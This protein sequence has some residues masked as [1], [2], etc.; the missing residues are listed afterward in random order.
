MSDQA[1]LVYLFTGDGKGK[2]S[3]ALGVAFRSLAAGLKVAMVQWYKDPTWRISEHSIDTLLTAEAKSRFKIYPM[4]VG[5]FIQQQAIQLSSN[6][7][8]QRINTAPLSN[9][10]VVVDKASEQQHQAAAQAALTK[11][12]EVLSTVDVLILDE[13]NN[14]I[15]DKL[16]SVPSVI[17]LINH[18]GQTH[19]ILTGRNAHPDIISWANLVTNME[20]VK[21]P[22]DQGQL[23]I[24][25]LDF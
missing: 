14:A 10:Q 23:A 2:T 6:P 16:I 21:H 12:A 20:K 25:G 17:N 7:A 8:I 9:G 1:G 3:A 4:G 24:K 19:L 13:I 5:F 18:R 22:Y 11:A 15:A